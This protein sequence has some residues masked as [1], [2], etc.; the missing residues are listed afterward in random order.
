MGKSTVGHLP[1][2]APSGRREKETRIPVTRLYRILA[3]PMLMVALALTL[4]SSARAEGAQD[5]LLDNQTGVDIH[6]LYVSPSDTNDWE[7]DLL[8][9]KVLVNDT[10]VHISFHPKTEAAHWDLRVDD[11]DGN[12]IYWRNLNLLEITEITLKPGGHAEAK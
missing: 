9:G 3:L 6:H 11:K 10:D 5:F 4:T 2:L 7:E 1:T 12:A 8:D